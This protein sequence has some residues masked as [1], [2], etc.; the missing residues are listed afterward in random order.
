M[1]RVVLFDLEALIRLA[2][3]ALPALEAGGIGRRQARAREHVAQDLAVGLA[4]GL[5]VRDGAR[6]R[7]HA[8][9]EDRGGGL[10]QRALVRKR[11]PAYERPV[12]VEEQEQGGLSPAAGTAACGRL[13]P[14]V[15]VP[16]RS[17]FDPARAAAGTAASG[18]PTPDRAAALH[19]RALE[20]LRRDARRPPALHPLERAALAAIRAAGPAPA[21][22]HRDEE[23]RL[24]RAAA[25]DRGDDRSDGWLACGLVHDDRVPHRPPAQAP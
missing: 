23:L 4:P 1:A 7:G 16:V 9:S 17:G 2:R 8:Q 10:L 21:L 3:A 15:V 12:D 18:P 5:Y 22:Q 13:L 19:A 11:P 20:R 24:A 25:L 14:K 6:A